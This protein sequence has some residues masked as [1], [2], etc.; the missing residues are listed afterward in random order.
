VGRRAHGGVDVVARPILSAAL[1]LTLPPDPGP[2]SP[3]CRWCPP[4]LLD[5]PKLPH[6]LL[7][8]LHR[9]GE[10][11]QT[12][13]RAQQDGLAK[14]YPL[15]RQPLRLRTVDLSVVHRLGAVRIEPRLGGRGCRYRV[16]PPRAP[17][18]ML[19]AAGEQPRR[20]PRRGLLL[21]PRPRGEVDRKICSPQTQSRPLS[22]LTDGLYMLQSAPTWK[23]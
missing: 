11:P 2:P 7:D 9:P 4:V 16:Q 22:P 17:H 10:V 21:P 15:A 12:L 13:L 6:V 23:P 5:P 1:P 20:Y 8:L 3:V 18:G 19:C 14:T